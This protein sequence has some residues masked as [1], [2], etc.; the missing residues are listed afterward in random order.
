MSWSSETPFGLSADAAG[1]FLAMIRRLREGDLKSD[2]LDS[3]LYDELDRRGFVEVAPD[4]GVDCWVLKVTPRGRAVLRGLRAWAKGRPVD[5]AAFWATYP[6]DDRQPIE[7]EQ[8]IFELTVAR[9]T[10]EQQMIDARFD[11]QAKR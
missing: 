3:G 2:L 5:M 8:R 11:A 9:K 1:F 7:I 6:K 10:L 4:E